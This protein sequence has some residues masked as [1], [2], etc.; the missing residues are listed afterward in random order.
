[1]GWFNKEVARTGKRV[2]E[3][4]LAPVYPCDILAGDQA[5]A[6]MVLRVQGELK[7]PTASG[8]CEVFNISL[9]EGEFI[10]Q[11]YTST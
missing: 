4:Q 6:Y 3:K 7:I 5:M 11:Y 9:S 10:L 8:R 1:M 2:I